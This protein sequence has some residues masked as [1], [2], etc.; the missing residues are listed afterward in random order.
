KTGVGNSGKCQTLSQPAMAIQ[1]QDWTPPMMETTPSDPNLNTSG[2]IVAAF[3]SLFPHLRWQ[4]HP[5]LSKT[6]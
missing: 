2:E 6:P 1:F 3:L 4:C 5:I